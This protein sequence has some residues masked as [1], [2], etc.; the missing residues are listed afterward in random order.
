MSRCERPVRCLARSLLFQ[1]FLLVPFVSVATAQTVT[2]TGY[3]GPITIGSARVQSS[4]AQ[5]PVPLSILDRRQQEVLTAETVLNGASALQ[6]GRIPVEAQG[7]INTGLAFTN[8][9]D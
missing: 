9:N 8:L 4:L 2:T 7:A 6:G 5:M 3:S 1:A